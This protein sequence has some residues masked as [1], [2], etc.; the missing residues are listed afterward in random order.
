MI[1]PLQTNASTITNP[2]DFSNYWSVSNVPF[3]SKVA[4]RGVVNN[5]MHSW[6]D[7]FQLNFRLACETEAALGVLV[8]ALHRDVAR[9]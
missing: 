6:M 7:P 1:H 5:F 9:V 4:E 3:L 2:G 8:D